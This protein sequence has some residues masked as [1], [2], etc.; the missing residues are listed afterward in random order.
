V[1]IE[2]SLLVLVRVYVVHHTVSQSS[3]SDWKGTQQVIG[4][5]DVWFLGTQPRARASSD[6]LLTSVECLADRLIG[7]YLVSVQNL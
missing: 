7:W 1:L 5:S 6:D 2:L 4:T 3:T